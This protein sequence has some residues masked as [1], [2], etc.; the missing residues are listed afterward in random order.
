[1]EPL[2]VKWFDLRSGIQVYSAVRWRC[3]MQIPLRTEWVRDVWYKVSVR[4]KHWPR[5][6]ERSRCCW[7]SCEQNLKPLAKKV[8]KM[9]REGCREVR[10]IPCPVVSV[11]VL[12]GFS[13]CCWKKGYIRANHVLPQI[14]SGLPASAPLS[15]TPLP[16]NVMVF[17]TQ[18]QSPKLPFTLLG[19]RFLSVLALSPTIARERLI[20]VC[21]ELWSL[22]FP[23]V[24]MTAFL[25]PP[26]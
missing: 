14:T 11:G 9:E 24:I 19:T 17:I 20:T 18:S 3:Q 8:V 7:Y 1:M 22:L 13:N 23:A 2:E 16:G 25:K 26:I 15:L 6:A 4:W 21:Y 5:G 10:E 12:Q